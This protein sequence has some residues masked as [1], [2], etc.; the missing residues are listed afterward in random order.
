MQ[1]FNLGD[2]AR[3]AR[4][5]R[6]AAS[7]TCTTGARTSSSAGRSA[8]SFNPVVGGP[9]RVVNLESSVGT[10]YDAL[11]VEPGEA[12]GRRPAAARLLHPRPR[13][14]TTRTTTRSRSASGPIDPN[15]LER[16]YGPTPNEQR[17]RFVLS[18]SFD[19][20]AGPPALAA[21]WTIASGGADGHPDARRL[22]RA[23]RRS[24]RNAGGR[25]FKTAAE[26]NAYLDGAQR[27][28]RHRRRAAAAR[29]ATTRASATASTRSTCA[30][31]AR[32]AVSAP[33]SLEAI[34]ECFN[35]FNVTNIL[36]V[37]KSNYSGFA[38]VLARDSSDPADPGY[39]RSSSFGQRADD[40]GRRLRLGRAA[41]LPARPEGA[42]LSAGAPPRAAAAH[43]AAAP[44]RRSWWAGRSAWGSS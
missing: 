20:P 2:A 30:S 37:S 16:E 29:A 7:T 32:F 34:V 33:L 40:G 6:P 44:P 41:G 25:E 38:N 18:G 19:L 27:G 3:G 15:D 22:E 12:L 28:G 39:L 4:R 21:I 17:H 1:Q 35:V 14:A 9:D 11:L 8:R 5:R 26:L 24:P 10:R 36:G 42:V 43:R 23:C 31:R 13:A